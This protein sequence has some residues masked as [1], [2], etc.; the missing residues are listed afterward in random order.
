MSPADVNAL[1]LQ[2]LDR[3]QRLDGMIRQ[4][5]D[6]KQLIGLLQ[7]VDSALERIEE[8]SYGICDVCHEDIEQERL[9]V[10]PLVRVCLDHLNST[11]QRALEQDLEMAS[12]IQ[13]ALL[14]KKK[15]VVGN[16]LA[17]FHYQP[18]GVV[19]GDYCDF[20]VNDNKP[21]SILFVIGDVSGKGI[22]ASLLMSH[23]HAMFHS[24][25]GFNQPVNQLVENA[26]RLFC[27]ST[28]STHFATL[29][30]GVVT[31]SGS[32]TL[33]NAGHCPPVLIKSDGVHTFSANGLPIGMFCNTQYT[34]TKTTLA[35][36]STLFLYTDGLNEANNDTEQY[37]EERVLQTL[38]TVRDPNPENLLV[39]M[40][41]DVYKFLNGHPRSDDLT[42]M[43]IRRST[44]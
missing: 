36:G 4:V 21:E 43:A 24:V 5:S 9:L 20:I 3:R 33:C 30:C 25:N 2:L 13:N 27:E 35:P 39:S 11:Q 7:E 42:M 19:S 44:T 29:V 28:L 41:N 34:V 26:N 17:A 37:G 12:R 1:R 15:V 32:V 18:A 16:L 38:S 6:P 22:A 31:A 14:P 10:D 40:S 8:G 23:L